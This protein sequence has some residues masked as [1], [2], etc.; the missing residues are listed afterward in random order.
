MEGAG[1]QKVEDKP[2]DH[3]L[4]SKESLY[5]GIVMIE[6]CL[7]LPVALV[8]LA[9]RRRCWEGN[10]GSHAEKSECALHLPAALVKAGTV[11]MVVDD[12]FT[13][14]AKAWDKVKCSFCYW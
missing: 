5:Q 9:E 11:Q 10:L 2:P 7:C 14:D 12:C 13:I 8:Q 6:C 3:N 1:A 4:Q